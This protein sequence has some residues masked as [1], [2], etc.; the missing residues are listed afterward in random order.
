MG[1]VMTEETAVIDTTTAWAAVEARDRRFDGALVYAVGTTGVYCRP[2]CPSRRA[3]RE[4]V[5]FHATPDEAEAAG[6]RECKRCR[7]R[8]AT[9]TLGEAAVLRAQAYLDANA[10]R[11]VSLAEVAREVGMSA[12]HLQRTFRRAHRRGVGRD[13]QTGQRAD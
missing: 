1:H 7:P 2:S 8:A 4:N 9:A 6:Y 5:T 12:F 10:D 13:R 11:R 3:H